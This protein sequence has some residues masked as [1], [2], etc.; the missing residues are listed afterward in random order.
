MSKL[1]GIGVGPGES[2]L[3][4]VKGLRI[5]R[6]ADVIICPSSQEGG[7]SIAYNT[8]KE[9]L[10]K[11]KDVRILHFPMGK[12]DTNE[13][14]F[15][16]YKIIEGCLD[17]GK[18][19]AF[20]T[21][22]DPYVYSTYIH[23]LTHFKEEHYEVETIPGITSFCAAASIVDTPL[24]IGDEPL[25]IVPARSVNRIKD[26]KFVVIMKVYKREEE[27]MNVLE[28]KGF[29]YVLVSRAGR[30]GQKVLYKKED[31]LNYRDYMSLIIASRK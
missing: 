23:L 25:M 26:E 4:T 1:Y 13:K 2:E 8:V 14:V 27:V 7:E 22:G 19:V 5:I 16:A 28:E 24:V 12:D 18:D 9:F 17:Q 10:D 20:L 11:D 15:N 6:E 3:L 21:L 30:E 29:D 31:I